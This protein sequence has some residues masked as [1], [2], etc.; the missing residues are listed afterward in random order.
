MSHVHSLYKGHCIRNF[1]VVLQEETVWQMRSKRHGPQL[2]MFLFHNAV[3]QSVFGWNQHWILI[4][5]TGARILYL[6]HTMQWVPV[7]GQPHMMLYY[8][9]GACAQT[10][11]HEAMPSSAWLFPDSH[12]WG[13]TTQRV[14][15]SGQPHMMLYH[16]VGACAQPATQSWGKRSY[17]LYNRSF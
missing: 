14:C 15:V 4:F 16:A 3:Q 13:Y 17:M 11:T 9:V 10:A 2:R 8:T 1:Q 6:R 5:L 12:T 7:P